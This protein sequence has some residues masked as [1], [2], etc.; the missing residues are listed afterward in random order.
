MTVEITGFVPMHGAE[1][2]ERGVQDLRKNLGAFAFDALVL[3][4]QDLREGKVKR[5]TWD[6]CVIS[7]MRGAPGSVHQDVDGRGGNAFTLLWDRRWMTFP[8]VLREVQAEIL[9][10][11]PTWKPEP[12]S[13]P[14]TDQPAE[15]PAAVEG[16][17]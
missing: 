9:R 6:G 15:V 17:S 12:L 13:A 1:V 5:G 16:V 3:L 10:R 4:E 14:A 8:V 2:Q 11:V 7:Y